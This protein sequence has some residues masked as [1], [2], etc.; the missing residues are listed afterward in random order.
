MRVIGGKEIP[1][2][3]GQ[4]GAYVTRIYPGGVVES[5]GEIKEGKKE[6]GNSLWRTNHRVVKRWGI[7]EFET[8]YQPRTNLVA[9]DGS[10]LLADSHKI[11]NRQ[12]TARRH[13]KRTVQ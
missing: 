2:T 8:G 12:K 7:N 5:L 6:K 3:G 4:L 9:D 11:L 10:Y 13:Q 1:G